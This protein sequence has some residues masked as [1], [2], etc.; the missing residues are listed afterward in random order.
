MIFYEVLKENIKSS[1]HLYHPD[2]NAPFSHLALLLHGVDIFP[3]ILTN[4]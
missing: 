1:K 3:F 4:F 2:L